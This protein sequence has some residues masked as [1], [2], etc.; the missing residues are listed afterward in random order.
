MEIHR[1]HTQLADS[2]KEV[3]NMRKQYEGR[4]CGQ[5]N[6]GTPENSQGNRPGI[7]FSIKFHIVKYK[8]MIKNK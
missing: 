1:L 6:Q 2:R 3:R 4:A 7:L 5:E 8:L